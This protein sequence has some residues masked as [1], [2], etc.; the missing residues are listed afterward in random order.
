MEQETFKRAALKAV[1]TQLKDYQNWLGFGEITILDALLHMRLCLIHQTDKRPSNAHLR[2]T[3]PGTAE[4]AELRAGAQR[5]EGVGLL[6][7]SKVRGDLR[8]SSR[9][10]PVMIGSPRYVELVKRSGDFV[11]VC[12]N[13]R[14]SQ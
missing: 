4:V 9:W 11:I 5:L 3:M 10:I 6:K 14:D 12:D 8:I 2:D 7:S 13:S 1:F